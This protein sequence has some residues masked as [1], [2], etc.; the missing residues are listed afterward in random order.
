MP[1]IQL[2]QGLEMSFA[3][4]QDYAGKGLVSNL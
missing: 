1:K 3:Y 4:F 2:R